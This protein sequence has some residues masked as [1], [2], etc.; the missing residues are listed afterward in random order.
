L[1][2]AILE[3]KGKILTYLGEYKTPEKF[4]MNYWIPTS[5]LMDV[6][7]F[8]RQAYKQEDKKLFEKYMVILKD[9]LSKS[10]SAIYEMKER[11]ITKKQPF[12][13]DV[14]KALDLR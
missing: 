13:N 9:M 12:R 14:L 10:G 11:A 4:P 2:K 5:I 6:L 1:A 8:A 3:G 7:F